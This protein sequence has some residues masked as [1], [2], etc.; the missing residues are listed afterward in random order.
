MLTMHPGEFL[1]LSFVER[2]RISPAE[3][4]RRA[5]VSVEEIEDLLEERADLSPELA[6]RLSY[7]IGASPEAWT[8]MQAYH[9]LRKALVAFDPE[10]LEP[11]DFAPHARKAA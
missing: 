4:A 5:N 3:I 9:N 10:G 7:V 2:K 6:V 1:K 8:H 11:F